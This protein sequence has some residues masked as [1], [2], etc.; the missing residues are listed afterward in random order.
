MTATDDEK[1]KMIENRLLDDSDFSQLMESEFEKAGKPE[2]VLATTR[3]WSRIESEINTNQS[4][5][6]DAN[7]ASNAEK[8]S[9]VSSSNTRRTQLIKLFSIAA[10]LALIV[11]SLTEKDRSQDE[12]LRIKGNA[13]LP[14]LVLKTEKIDG[15]VF[16]TYKFYFTVSD[17]AWTVLY[18]YIGNS[19]W[20]AVSNMSECRV[21]E[22]CYAEISSDLI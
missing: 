7:N 8:E 13:T 4:S 22:S 5:Q 11:F 14:D 21:G 3:V 1:N 12:T 16:Q 6:N 9:L 2:D 17:L 10:L 15:T 19:K 18:K 20:E